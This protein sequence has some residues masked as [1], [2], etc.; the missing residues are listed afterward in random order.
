MSPTINLLGSTGSIGTQALEV[1]AHYNRQVSPDQQYIV[2]ALV[3]RSN[4]PLLKEQ[5]AQWK[6][7]AVAIL[8]EESSSKFHSFDFSPPIAFYAGEK[9]LSAFLDVYPADVTLNALVGSSGIVPTLAA[10]RTGSHVLLANKETLVAAGTYVMDAARH[11]GKSII[12]VDSE[13]SAVFQCLQGTPQDRLKRI[14]LTCSGGPFRT[15]TQEQLQTVTV[16]Q[17]LQHPTWKMGNKI[18]VDS[19][20]LMNKGFE[21]LEAHHLFGLPPDRIEVVIHP[22]S[23]VHSFVEF[24]DGSVLA[25]I[26]E[27][28]MRLPIQYAL[29]SVTGGRLPSLCS[30]F[31]P[32]SHPRWTFS[33]PDMEKFPCLAYAYEALRVGGSLPTVLNAANE[34]AVKK[35]LD[36]HLP[37][38]GIPALIRHALDEHS[39]MA[40]P[41]LEDIL[42]VDA[43]VKRRYA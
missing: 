4:V 25:Q 31:T 2:K 11:A 5:A 15:Y 41:S 1:L 7:R 39:V 35:F 43:D 9:R 28:D 12:P 24:V 16:E 42:A 10:L 38:M 13:H 6:P 32:A 23:L 26:N 22:E 29:T 40:S 3:C 14:I 30:P 34:V 37:F 17:A 36:G 8:D 21:V 27:P 20:T 19:A 33:E 18:T